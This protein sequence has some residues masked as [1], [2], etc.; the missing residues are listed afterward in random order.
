[1]ISLDKSNKIVIKYANLYAAY[2]FAFT[3][4]GEI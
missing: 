1:M 3:L 2:K 4:W